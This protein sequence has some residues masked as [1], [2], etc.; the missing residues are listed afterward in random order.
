MIKKGLFCILVLFIISG[1]SAHTGKEE[2]GEKI[3]NLEQSLDR[4]DSA[5]LKQQVEGLLKAYEDNEWKIQLIGDEGE[6][7]KLH[8]SINRL[9]VSNEENDIT[10][11]KLELSTIKTILE[12]I[13]SF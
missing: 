4:Y 2:F 1:C 9:I 3:K 13:Y 6:Y 10:G 7:E 5:S 8:E 12:D 11:L